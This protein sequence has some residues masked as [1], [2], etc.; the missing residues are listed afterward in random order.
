M[1]PSRYSKL[2]VSLWQHRWR[3][4][5][6]SLFAIVLYAVAFFS[7]SVPVAMAGSV[8]VGPLVFVPWTIFCACI[9]FHPEF[10]SLSA[11][12]SFVG[13][14]PTPMAAL[15]RWYA[16]LCV[17]LFIFVGAIVWPALTFLWL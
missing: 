10:G 15:V 14:L 8:L 9:A 7:A 11:N 6:F 13:R 12:K 1:S 3:F 5:A 17:S 2:A 16:A 4:F